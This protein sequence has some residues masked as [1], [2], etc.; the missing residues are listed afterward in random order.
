MIKSLFLV[1]FVMAAASP[2]ARAQNAGGT[3]APQG[4]GGVGSRSNY[5]TSTGATVARPGESQSGGTTSLDRGVE[6][7]DSK[8]EGSICKGC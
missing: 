7:E 4:A 2:G 5:I 1:A 3:G 8:I 6:K